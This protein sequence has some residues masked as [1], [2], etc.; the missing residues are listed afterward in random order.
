MSELAEAYA[1]FVQD[2]SWDFYSTVTFR[3]LRR[4]SLAAAKAVWDILDGK[5]NA[6]RAF[7]AVEQHMLDGV[8]LHLLHQHY[9]E[10]ARLQGVRASS[11]WAYLFKAFG[12]TSV[13]EI[14]SAE[15]VSMYVSKYVSKGENYNLFGEPAAWV[16]HEP[17]VATGLDI[18]EIE[19]CSNGPTLWQPA[20]PGLD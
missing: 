15:D 1:M 8:H 18:N 14:R 13:E 2:Y 6:T 20:L 5:F 7:I 11:M 4:D 17:V 16:K 10:K 12:R 3:R 9:Y 19:T